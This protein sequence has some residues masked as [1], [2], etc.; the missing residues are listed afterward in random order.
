MK[1]NFVLLLALV[2][3]ITMATGCW[4]R[5]ELND[6]A[7]TVAIG[8]DKKGDQYKVSAQIVNPNEVASKQVSSKGAPV[9]TYSETGDTLFEALRKM[10]TKAP[11]K[12]FLSHLRMLVINE[13]LAKEGIGKA[14]DFL[15]RDHEIRTDFFI[16]V[17][18]GVPAERILDIYTVPQEVIPA[19]KMFKS[20]QTSSE[21]WGGN[22]KITIDKLISDIVSKG[23][24]PVITGV[25]LTGDRSKQETSTD[26]NVRTIT[27]ISILRFAGMAVFKEDKLVGWLNEEESKAYNYIQDEIKSTAQN[28][29]CPNGGILSL[30]VVRS[31]SSMKGKVVNGKLEVDLKLVLEQNVADVEC[32]IDLTKTQTIKEL[33]T[34]M[35]KSLRK[36]IVKTINKAKK[37]K[38]DIFG[39]GETIH[40]SAPKEWKKMKNNWDDEF[41]DLPVNVTVDA[42]IRRVGTITDTFLTEIKE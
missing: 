31:K 19:N 38:A 15:S 12:L 6:I 18:K 24:Q 25:D 41:V 36:T 22:G 29:S 28:V 23:K 42:K 14:L 26:E 37:L 1:R 34:R 13:E 20:L 5:R 11:R 9:I 8:L 10:T 30:E 27:P 7:I 16:A 35:E 2:F 32:K 39:F 17:A 4:S 33:E 21:N 3:T 40:R